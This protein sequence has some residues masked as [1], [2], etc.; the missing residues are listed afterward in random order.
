[1]KIKGILF[2]TLI[3][4]AAFIVIFFLLQSHLA[5][6]WD[7]KYNVLDGKFQVKNE[8]F[9][10]YKKDSD[11]EKGILRAARDV[12]TKKNM[13]LDAK[14]EKLFN[15]NLALEKELEEEK[16]KTEDLTGEELCEKL[17]ERVPDE[18]T[19]IDA[20]GFHLTRKGGELTLNLFI[21]EEKYRR[22]YLNISALQVDKDKKI[23][24]FEKKNVLFIKDLAITE[25][26][27]KKAIIALDSCVEAKDSLEK[28][29]KHT[30]WK[31]RGKGAVGGSLITIIILKILRVF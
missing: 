9:E 28:L 15:E 13:R 12:E 11:V 7:T 22:Q 2:Y 26:Q 14:I 29:F 27:A 31:E 25:E 8:D 5:K 3:L 24:S 1:M 19:L 23:S 20:G 21:D 17:N 30:K 16:K 18:Y 4:I 10:T 6:K